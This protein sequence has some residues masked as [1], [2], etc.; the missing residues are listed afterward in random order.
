MPQC[1]PCFE[2]ISSDRYRRPFPPTI[3]TNMVDV[4]SINFSDGSIVR[5]RKDGGD[6]TGLFES[7]QAAEFGART[8]D[9]MGGGVLTLLGDSVGSVLSLSVP[10]P[11]R[12]GRGRSSRQSSRQSGPSFR[13]CV[14][15]PLGLCASASVGMS[16]AV[17]LGDGFPPWRSTGTCSQDRGSGGIY[18]LSGADDD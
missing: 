18:R 15:T 6:L 12:V 4:F 8:Q 14:D 9:K 10:V 7:P 2:L 1:T 13:R 11:F 17:C 16:V 3:P 5:E